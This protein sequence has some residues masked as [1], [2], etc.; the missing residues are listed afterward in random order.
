MRFLI[1]RKADASTEAGEVPDAALLAAMGKYNEEL[2]K[3]GIL[4]AGE[5][6]HP[7]A[8]GARVKFSGGQPRVLDGPFAETK[9]LIAGFT[10]IDVR[11]KE[12]AIEWLKRWPSIDA[13][14]EVELELRRVYELSDFDTGPTPEQKD[15]NAR[16][17]DHLQEA[18]KPLTPQG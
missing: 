5:G 8:Q 1:L 7:S 9:E 10:V 2:M 12:E 15:A 4:V 3:A 17:R 6:L 13:R 16:M 14:G 11:S 18:G